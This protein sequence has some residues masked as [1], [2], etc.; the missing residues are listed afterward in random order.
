MDNKGFTLM[1]LLVVVIIL[2]ILATYVGVK[3]VSE[4]ERARINQAKIQIQAFEQALKIYQ[5]ENGE[6]PSTE[7]GLKALVEKPTT[8]NIPKKWKEGGYLDKPKVPKDPWDNDYVY[9]N[10]GLHNP[11]SVDVFTYGPDGQA[12]GE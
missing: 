12:G 3:L 2:G 1:E 8:G 10:P 4:P 7:Q 5:M 11:D 6:Y 9:L